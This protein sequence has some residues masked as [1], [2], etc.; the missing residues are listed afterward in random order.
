MTGWIATLLSLLLA[1]WNWWTSPTRQ[2]QADSAEIR[3]IPGAVED[4]LEGAKRE[5]A[6]KVSQGAAK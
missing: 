2:R 1:V 4:A 6:H 3:R 5:H